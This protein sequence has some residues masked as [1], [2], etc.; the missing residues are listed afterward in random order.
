MKKRTLKKLKLNK[1]EISKLENFAGGAHG[2]AEADGGII[3]II[4]SCL[5]PACKHTEFIICIDF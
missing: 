4:G 3:G 5:G 1:A 2:A